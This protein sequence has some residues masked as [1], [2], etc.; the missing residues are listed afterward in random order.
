M[1]VAEDTPLKKVIVVGAHKTGTTSL[2]SAMTSLGY[3]VAGFIMPG[4]DLES[5]RGLDREQARAIV[6]D[7]ASAM[8][9]SFDCAEDTPWWEIYPELD[10]RFPGSRFILTI[11]DPDRWLE[12][13]LQH[14]GDENIVHH[15]WIYGTSSAKQDPD[16]YRA[17]YLRH[18]EAVREYFADRP[19]DLLVLDLAA[20]D[21]WPELCAFLG[22]PVP[23]YEFP[24]ANA[25][26]GRG[27]LVDRCRAVLT[28]AWEMRRRGTT[29]FTR[30]L[31]LQMSAPRAFHRIRPAVAGVLNSGDPAGTTALVDLIDTHTPSIAALKSE[32]D[33]AYVESVEGSTEERWSRFRF[34]LLHLISN[35][36][37][38]Q[39]DRRTPHGTVG[40]LAGEIVA[41]VDT[42]GRGLE[43]DR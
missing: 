17:H 26:A 35:I 23:P 31:D 6:V 4:L 2:A 29:P 18:N 13:V 22:V 39:V 10:E 43:S 15:E 40:Q 41:A 25:R 21:G 3:R 32:I 37:E 33:L 14:F 16:R 8:L 34:E 9:E 19:D 27:T 28:R 24:H 42:F 12:S 38:A 7:E 36:E 20:G 5:L 1:D 30:A 11:R